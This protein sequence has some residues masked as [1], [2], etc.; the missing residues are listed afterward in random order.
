M[1]WLSK[2]FVGEDLDQLQKDL[3]NQDQQLAALNQDRLNSGAYSD[4]VYAEAEAHRLGGKLDVTG[5]VSQA[6]NESIQDSVSGAAGVVKGVIK[7]PFDF[8]FKALPWEIWLIAAVAIFFYLGG[9][10]YLK[11]ILARGK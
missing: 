9:G 10:I 1:S 5:E 6:F 4:A 2:L 8:L 3:D 11:G 7:T